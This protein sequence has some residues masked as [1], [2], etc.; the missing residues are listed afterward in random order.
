MYATSLPATVKKQI[1]SLHFIVEVQTYQV[2]FNIK[3]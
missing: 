2:I 3:Y 1:F